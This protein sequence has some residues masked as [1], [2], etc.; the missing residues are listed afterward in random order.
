MSVSTA[1]ALNIALMVG[2]V[3]VLLW[4][5]AHLG[6][7]QGLRHDRATAFRHVPPG[8]RRRRLRKRAESSL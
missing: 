5:L 1:V 6:I 4:L 3:L 7:R 8:R 2:L